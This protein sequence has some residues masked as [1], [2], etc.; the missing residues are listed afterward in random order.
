MKGIA[1]ICCFIFLSFS[2]AQGQELTRILFILDASNSM[3]ANWGGQTRIEAAKELLVKTVDSL[4]GSAN[5]Q[6]ALR[7]YGH[8]SPITATY[9]DCNDTKLEVPFGPDNFMKVRN[10]IR[11]IMAKGTTPIARS[12]EAAAGDFPDTNAR[13]IIILITDGLE[14]CDNDPCVIAKKLHDKGV[15]VTPFVIGLGLDLS[16]LD[17]FKCIGSY[18]EAE[19]KEAFN[20]VLKTVISKALI[21]TTVQINLNNINK[22]PNETDV[23]M[24]LYKAGTKEL[25][26]TFVHTLN[27]QGNPD[28]LT[29][30]P[31]MK[32]DLVV[33]T[34]PKVYKN[35]I[36]IVKNIHNVIP[37]D[38]PQGFIKLRFTNAS[39][40]Y[41][42]LSRVYQKTDQKTINT[43]LVG[44]T[45]KY[46][47][48][49][50]EVEILSLPRIYHTVEVTQS[51]TETIDLPA[52]GQFSYNATKMVAAQ[53]FV[54][55]EDGTV[56]WVCNLDQINLKGLIYLQPGNYRVVYRQKQLK[57]TTYTTE[58]NFKIQ[59]NK[60][61][62]INL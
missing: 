61:T 54:I 56:E 4:N 35:N 17:Q 44:A 13:N 3:N 55:R 36:S 8:Q 39:S 34:I 6:I 57:S 11:T 19:T 50:Y 1:V 46:I 21:N 10:K 18:S 48:G 7:V 42:V 62:S 16:Y 32:Y 47:V 58:K 59:S 23:T 25:M 5:L 14:A 2:K 22:V 12:L 51:A 31:S 37:V 43:Q 20:N 60:T 45:D 27:R 49:K 40:P 52:P 29:M 9:Q 28:T 15:K 38:C 53:I 41:Q 26:Y 24:L 33:N 30:D